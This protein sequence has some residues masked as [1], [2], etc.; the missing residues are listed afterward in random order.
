M[1]TQWRHVVVE[2][3]AV[4]WL[5]VTQRGARGGRRPYHPMEACGGGNLEGR[6]AAELS[7]GDAGSSKI[8][9]PR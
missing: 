8:P 7:G 3:T 9:W 1:A 4:M 2:K 5:A 6:R